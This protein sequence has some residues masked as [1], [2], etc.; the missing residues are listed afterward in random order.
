MS[1]SG[2]TGRAIPPAQ[3]KKKTGIQLLVG[4]LVLLAFVAVALVAVST[5]FVWP[6]ILGGV[7]VIAGI[8]MMATS[9]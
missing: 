9:K 3:R 6:S 1:D 5:W 2:N 8:V 7:C 4:G